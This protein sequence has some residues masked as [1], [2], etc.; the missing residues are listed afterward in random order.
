MSEVPKRIRNKERT[1]ALLVTATKDQLIDRGFHGIS[2]QVILDAA[3]IKRGALFHHFPT[4]DH[5]IAAAFSEL[6]D[7]LLKELNGVA[8]KLRLGRAT[9]REFSEE[10]SLIVSKGHFHG[11]MEVA[12]AMRTAFELSELIKGAV[13]DWRSGFRDFWANTF[14]LPGATE[15]EADM[16][17]SLASDVLRGHAFSMS[18]GAAPVA[19]RRHIDG[20]TK[21]F[22][23]CADVRPFESTV[24][25]L[26][27]KN[28][29]RKS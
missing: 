10:I 12:L 11:C 26:K 2:I 29:G 16:H 23:E 13:E 28:S 24:T 5:L 8:R 15:D 18:F 14:G 17:W 6:L 22:L 25:T 3:Q 4:K 20:F 19:H 9:K 21:V 7:D 1:I 27:T